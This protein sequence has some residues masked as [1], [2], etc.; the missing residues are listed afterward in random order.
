MSTLNCKSNK[1]IV[2]RD[3]THLESNYQEKIMELITCSCSLN[4]K[5]H[6]QKKSSHSLKII[7]VICSTYL[8]YKLH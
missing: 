8:N 5:E 7:I 6:I 2:V 3:P 4:I 1:H